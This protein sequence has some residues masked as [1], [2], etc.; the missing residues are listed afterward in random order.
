VYSIV[1]APRATMAA[2]SQFCPRA[3]IT[4]QPPTGKGMTSIH[5]RSK[6][7]G[8]PGASNTASGRV[9]FGEAGQ[10]QQLLAH[11]DEI[12]PG[13][14]RSMEPAHDAGCSSDAQLRQQPA[15]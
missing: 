15:R 7:R 5:P 6:P 1:A 2:Q 8:V 13:Q 14:E 11:H 12:A 9:A 3:T 10:R 4:S